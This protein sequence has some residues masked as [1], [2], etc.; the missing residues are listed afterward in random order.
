ML[1]FIKN[2]SV[3]GRPLNLPYPY[4]WIIVTCRWLFFD[5]YQYRTKCFW[6]YI[7]NVRSQT[8]FYFN[9]SIKIIC[10]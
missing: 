2:L 4:H 8:S 10:I 1:G 3:V 5:W 6:F 7:N 9:H